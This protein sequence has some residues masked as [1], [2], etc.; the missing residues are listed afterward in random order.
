MPANLSLIAHA[1]HGDPL[2]AAIHRPGDRATERRLT[3]A[4]RARQ[5]EDGAARPGLEGEHGEVLKDAV[6]HLLQAKVIAI[7]DLFG[8]PEIDGFGLGLFPRQRHDPLQVA[9]HHPVLG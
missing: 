1:A 8:Q 2:K 7:E 9:A 5:A 4:G 3:D 6:L